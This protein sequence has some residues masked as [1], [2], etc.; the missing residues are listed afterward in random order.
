MCMIM[1]FSL[2]FR[3]YKTSD[4]VLEKKLGLMVVDL[5]ILT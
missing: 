5:D 2:D 1:L 3:I 4:K